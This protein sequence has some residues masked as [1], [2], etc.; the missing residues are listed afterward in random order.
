MTTE[1]RSADTINATLRLVETIAAKTT[2]PPA[3]K[4]VAPL[5][6][7]KIRPEF[8]KEPFVAGRALSDYT[9]RTP[10][11]E[12]TYV[13]VVEH[14]EWIEKIKQPLTPEEKAELEA[15]R[16]RQ[17]QEDKERRA[18][19]AKVFLG[20]VGIVAGVAVGGVIL[21]GKEQAKAVVETANKVSKKTTKS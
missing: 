4:E 17:R 7:K 12:G 15:Q 13:H 9:T 3:P 16:E 18:F 6:L 1:D 14:K 5:P 8:H 19:N 2:P 21:A 11:D 20:F 10:D